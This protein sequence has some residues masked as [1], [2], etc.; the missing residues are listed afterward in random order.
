MVRNYKPRT[1]RATFDGA[2]VVR[3]LEELDKRKS[4]RHVSNDL[5]IPKT[6]LIPFRKASENYNNKTKKLYFQSRDLGIL[7]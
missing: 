7:I 2:L 4:L 3:A 1:D 6:T 5:H